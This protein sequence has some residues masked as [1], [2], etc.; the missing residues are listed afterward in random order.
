MTLQEGAY[1]A[2]IP[3]LPYGTSVSYSV[4]AFDNAGNQAKSS[5]HSYN[6][7]DPYPPNIGVPSWSPVQPAAFEEI[8]INV[9]ATEPIN[10][11]G[12]FSVTLFYKNKTEDE[13]LSLPMTLKNGNYTVILSGQSDTSVQ[14][15]IEAVDK[16][17][18]M[19]ESPEQEL[20]VS[21]PAAVPL[22]WILA[23]ILAIT[24]V[25]GGSAYY[26]RKQQKKRPAATSPAAPS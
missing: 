12:I 4:Y 18:N 14:F 24:A 22:A 20:T 23:V 9:T 1:T 2:S 8:T 16:A 11:S 25:I 6:V 13:W 15:F 10:A 21:P 3:A 7:T 19:A 26:A 5:L 17:G